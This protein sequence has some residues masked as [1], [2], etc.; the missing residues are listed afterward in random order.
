MKDQKFFEELNFKYDYLLKKI[1]DEKE[2]MN[3]NKKEYDN[4]IKENNYVMGSN[5]AYDHLSFLI[6]LSR[7]DKD[8]FNY[9]NN[10]INKYEKILS[11]YSFTTLKNRFNKIKKA[12]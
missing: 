2:L 5:L 6:N 11:G 3:T 9:L 7:E 4:L 1:E 8:I 10:N 12:Y